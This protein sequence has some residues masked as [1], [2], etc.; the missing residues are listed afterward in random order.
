MNGLKVFRNLRDAINAGYQVY[1][2]M[3]DGYLVRT[4]TSGGWAL[5]IV[6]LTAPR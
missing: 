4:R 3:A 2:R 5:A 1:D 6:Q